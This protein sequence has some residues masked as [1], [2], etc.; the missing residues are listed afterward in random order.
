MLILNY[1]KAK[2]GSIDLD[3]PNLELQV[4][5]SGD[6]AK[7]SRLTNFVVISFSVLNNKSDVMSSRGMLLHILGVGNHVNE[8]Y[9][10][11]NEHS[12]ITLLCRIMQ[13]NMCFT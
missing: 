9:G 3:D 12:Y 10:E 6:G 11:A 13:L 5:L 1:F 4:K 2:E 8:T 7:M